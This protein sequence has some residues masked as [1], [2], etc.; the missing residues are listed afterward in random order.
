MLLFF[1]PVALGAGWLVW[2]GVRAGT[3]GL[4]GGIRGQSAKE[5]NVGECVYYKK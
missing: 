4:T 3:R 1:N 5:A 2:R